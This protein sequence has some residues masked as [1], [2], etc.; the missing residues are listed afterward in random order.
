MYDKHYV[1]LDV[2][3]FSKNGTH[4]PVSKVTLNVDSNISYSSG[5]DSG[6]EISADCPYATQVM[7]DRILASIK[8]CE[9]KMYNATDANID[10]AAELGDGVTTCGLYS[11][12]GS[13]SDD[14]YGYPDISAPGEEELEYQYPYE[15][16]T[17]RKLDNLESEIDDLESEFEDL[18][19]EFD[20]LSEMIGDLVSGIAGVITFNGRDGEVVPER[21]DY[22]EFIVEEIQKA[23]YASWAAEY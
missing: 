4:R 6:F 8:G 18:K 7:A 14:G 15:S 23:I 17:K 11:V 2:K 1:G 16:Y 5:D 22:L 3:G 20:E 19:T 10:P 13:I 21:E 12:I 9:Y